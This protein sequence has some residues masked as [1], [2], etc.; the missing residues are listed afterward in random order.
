MDQRLDSIRF[1][2]NYIPREN[3]WYAWNDFSQDSIARDLDAIAALGADHL[4]IM[5]VWPYLQPNRGWVSPAHLDRL[6]Q[7]MVLTAER[8]LDVCPALYTGWLSGWPFRPVFD[9]GRDFYREP[10]MREPSELYMRACAERLN[11]HAN[12]LGFDLGNEMN[13][14]WKTPD[15]RDGDLWME[16]FLSLAEE[17]CPQAVHVNGVDHQP[18]FYPETFTPGFLAQRQR[19]I[20]LHCWVEFTGALQRGDHR[21]RASVQL[22]PAMAALARKYAGDMAKPIWLQEFGATSHWMPEAEIP[23]F[24]EASVRAAVAGGVGRITWWASHDISPKF[25]FPE[26]EYDMGLLDTSNR[27]K[28]VGETFRDLAKELSGRALTIPDWGGLPELPV[29]SPDMTQSE[30]HQQTWR[31]IEEVQGIISP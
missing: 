10:A 4:R 6:D 28:K 9:E 19:L 13:G 18:W 7:L 30:L 12:F 11:Q 20:A 5:L 27:P 2:V 23:A 8:N 17:L 26:I 24:L 21:H 15:P 29:A 3:W 22:V 14:C 1:G 16:H 31:W 25:Q